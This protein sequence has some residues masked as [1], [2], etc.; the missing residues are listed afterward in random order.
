MSYDMATEPWCG[1]REWAEE[2]KMNRR[3]RAVWGTLK[4]QD[5]AV[6]QRSPM[7][8]KDCGA[9]CLCVSPLR[10]Y[11]C[12]H[13]RLHPDTRHHSKKNRSVDGE[14][15]KEVL[16]RHFA[17]RASPLTWILARTQ[18]THPGEDTPPFI[19]PHRHSL[20]I[21]SGS[22]H[23]ADPDSLVSPVS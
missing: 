19:H 11:T 21:Q 1:S 7:G 5:T 2:Y 23:T 4:K 15:V 17:R 3:W 14:S 16:P 6:N 12:M 9:C 8:G 10:T 13:T 22:D 18:V 20:L